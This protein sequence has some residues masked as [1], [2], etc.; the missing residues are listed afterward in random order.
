MDIRM[1]G[2]H[3][4]TPVD[5]ALRMLLENVKISGKEE[6]RFY[7]ALKR[8]L[9]EDVI[10]ERDNPPFNRAAMDGYAVKG[11][12][13][14]GASQT[15][16]I[17]FKVVGEVSTGVESQLE[18]KDFEAVKIMTGGVMPEGSDAVVMFE[19]TTKLEG[20]IEVLRPVTPGKNVSLKG[21]DV[22]RGEVLLKKGRVIKPHDIG[23]L[24]AIGKTEIKVYKKPRVAIISTGDE[25]V[26]PSE[27]LRAG[28]IY[29]VNSYALSSLVE[30]N[31]GVAKRI[32]IVRDNYKELKTALNKA[33]K[34]DMI[35]ISGATS[36]GKRDVIPK[37][38]GELGKILVHGVPM[39]PGEPTG[40]GLVKDK[41]VF[42]LPGYPVAA[43][44]GFETFVRPALQKMQGREIS[45]PYPQ[46]KATL[47]RKIASELGRR[48]FVRV[49]L[50]KSAD[51]KLFVEPI[52]TSGSGIIS[53][54]VRADGFVIV[55]E[56]TE[57]LEKGERV[58]VNVY[59][60]Q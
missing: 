17:Y 36:V 23:I 2:F 40:F 28:E 8:V 33:L 43:I 37:I 14:F 10:A 11:E 16:P 21:E 31:S 19:Y 53:S 20:E 5:K 56:S 32:G 30:I 50:E 51:D 42:M 1:R 7:E 4:R 57:G 58:V 6:V 59:E 18:V 26:E 3:E 46:V 12:N 25:L 13:T 35:L 39:R 22:K 24:A 34:Y 60:I 38:V 55:P 9:A 52:R 27:K 49:R 15:N 47:K 54:V 29:D 48:D 45:N 41:P 44:V